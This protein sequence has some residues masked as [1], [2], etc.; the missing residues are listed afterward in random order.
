MA[1]RD[2][3]L[4]NAGIV[5]RHEYSDRVRSPLFLLSTV[6]LMGLAL[7]VALAPIA[8]RYLDQQRVARIAI[9]ADDDVLAAATIATAQG[10][11]NI[12]PPGADLETWTAP[13]GRDGRPV[14]AFLAVRTPDDARAL[15]VVTDPDGAAAL[16]SGDAGEPAGAKLRVDADGTAT[17]V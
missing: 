17:L 15:A 7:A 11:M 4:P 1:R 8:I 13:F 12:A 10:I 6:I 2:P 3:L 5:A 9:V 14:K 16:V